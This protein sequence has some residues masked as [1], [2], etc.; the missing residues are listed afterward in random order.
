MPTANDLP[1][2]LETTEPDRLATG[3]IFTEG[4]LWHPD[5]YWYFGDL[6][7]DNAQLIDEAVQRY[8]GQLWQTILRLMQ[9]D[10][11]R[12]HAARPA[13]GDD[14]KL[15]EVS[16]QRIDEHG[17]LTNQ[18]VAHLVQHQR[19]LLVSGLDGNKA[20]RRP[21]H[22][23]SDC[24]GIGDIGLAALHVWFDIGRRHQ[25]NRVPQLGEF[26]SPV[27]SGSAG[28]HSDKAARQSAEKPQDIAA[29]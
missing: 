4:P 9:R 1:E 7:S 14:A 20:H 13:C 15:R 24:L 17:S 18:K 21:G 19:C 23:F 16:T 12:G 10:D 28:L 6:A 2:V 26:T 29:A 22:R 27:M 8:P 11:C 25:S 5:G 3:F